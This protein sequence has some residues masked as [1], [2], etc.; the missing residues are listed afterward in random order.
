MEYSKLDQPIDVYIIS[1]Q[2]W[3]RGLIMKFSN[4]IGLRWVVS[5]G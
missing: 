3:K 4:E 2:V 1:V 5:E